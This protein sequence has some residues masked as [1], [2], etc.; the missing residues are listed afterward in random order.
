MTEYFSAVYMG[1]PPLATLALQ[2]FLPRAAPGR[3]VNMVSNTAPIRRLL[4]GV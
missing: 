4:H 3:A 1:F 2:W